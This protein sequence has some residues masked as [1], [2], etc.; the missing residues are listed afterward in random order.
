MKRKELARWAHECYCMS[1]R[2]SCRVMQ[3]RRANWYYVSRARDS[4]AVRQRMRELAMLRPRFGY[5]RIHILL[6]REGWKDTRCG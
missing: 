5:E 3:L 1:V 6:R 2:R 4:G